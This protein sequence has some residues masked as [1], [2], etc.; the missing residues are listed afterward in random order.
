MPA[1]KLKQVLNRVPFKLLAPLFIFV[2]C[3]SIVLY[4][5]LWPLAYLYGLLLCTRIWVEWGKQ[6]KD[7]LLIYTRS[8]HSDDWMARILS[9]LG[10]RAVLLN[11]D[12]R[13]HWNRWSPEVQL[14]GIFGPRSIPDRFTPEL[15][16]AAIIFRQFRAPKKLTF[17]ERSKDRE[18]R[19]E[20]LRSELTVGK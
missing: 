14:F 5:V 1:M 2:N 15:L 7:V 8:V 4:L 6:G 3:L 20:Q 18:D 17:G 9:L 13:E 12:E 11:Y 19:L 10:N 16:P